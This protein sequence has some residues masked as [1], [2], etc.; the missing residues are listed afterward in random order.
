MTWESPNFI[1]INLGVSML[2]ENK[3]DELK[4]YRDP[5][6]TDLMMRS[7]VGEIFSF[8]ASI[9]LDIKEEIDFLKKL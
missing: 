2:N 5:N 4:R 3:L 1:Q 6:Y 7:E 8:L 9:I